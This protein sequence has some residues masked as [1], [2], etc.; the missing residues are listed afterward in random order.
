[1]DDFNPQNDFINERQENTGRWLLSSQEFEE[2]STG[3]GQTLFCHG[4]PG[5]GKTIITSLVIDHLQKT[6]RN[7]PDVGVAYAHCNLLK[8]PELKALDILGSLLGQFTHGQGSID[9][10]L[11]HLHDYHRSRQSHPCLDEVIQILRTVIARYTTAFIVVDA[12]DEFGDHDGERA[13]FLR[14]L[15]ELQ[16]ETKVNLF[17]TS[18]SIP[19]VE[20]LFESG[21][22]LRICANEDDVKRFLDGRLQRSFSHHLP[23]DMHDE[24]KNK[25]VEAADGM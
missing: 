19:E 16:G 24:I 6:F 15:F 1:M 7:S 20:R 14:A 25:I 22:H 4:F 12:L 17:A 8:Y 5:S 2:W 23:Q 18:R 10:D 21:I 11:R 3:R 13:T 9:K